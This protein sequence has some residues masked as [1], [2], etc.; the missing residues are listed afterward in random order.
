MED[1]GWRRGNEKLPKYKYWEWITSSRKRRSDAMKINCE[2]SKNKPFAYSH[3]NKHC[4]Y[5]HKIGI[6][7]IENKYPR[8]RWRTSKCDV[9]N[10]TL[11]V[12]LQEGGWCGNESGHE[13]EGD[14]ATRNHQ[15]ALFQKHHLHFIS[16]SFQV[17][18]YRNNSWNL[19]IFAPCRVSH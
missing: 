15:L 3:K 9:D 17:S 12:Q 14:L 11:R 16:I 2:N 5:Y 18:N 1:E 7:R 4:A 10:Q 13:N 19:Y 6:G 8:V